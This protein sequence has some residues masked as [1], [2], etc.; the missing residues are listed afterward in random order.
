MLRN[1]V[2]G[3]RVSDLPEQSVTKMYGSMLL[4]LR[5]GGCVSN[6]QKNRYVTLEWPPTN[7]KVILPHN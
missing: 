7:V 5:G 1:T 6:F 4:A 3:R 2:G